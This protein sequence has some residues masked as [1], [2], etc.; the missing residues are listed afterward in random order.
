MRFKSKFLQPK[1]ITPLK[2]GAI[3]REIFNVFRTPDGRIEGEDADLTVA[4]K[5]KDAVTGRAPVDD[6]LP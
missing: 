6:T 2:T 4:L 3:L 5:H 1:T